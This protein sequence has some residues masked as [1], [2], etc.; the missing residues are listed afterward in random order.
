MHKRPRWLWLARSSELYQASLD[1]RI[2]LSESGLISLTSFNNL[3]LHLLLH[4]RGIQEASN[5]KRDSAISVTAWSLEQGTV[6]CPQCLFNEL[7]GRS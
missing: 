5:S 4:R 2:G 1:E 3:S 6:L 7:S